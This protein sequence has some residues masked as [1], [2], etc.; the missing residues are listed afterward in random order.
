MARRRRRRPGLALGAR[1]RERE[2]LAAKSGPE[3]QA[4]FVGAAALMRRV[5]GELAGCD[6][7][8]VGLRRDCPD[9]D[10]P[11]GRPVPTGAAQGGTSA[12]R[13][14]ARTSSSPRPRG[15]SASTSSSSGR[16]R[17]RRRS[18]P[19]G[20]ARRGRACRRRGLRPAVGGQEAYLK[21]LGTGL[22]LPMS[23]VRVAEDRA[24]LL[25]GSAPQGRLER[26]DAPRA[27]SRGCA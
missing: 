1:R 14:R 13:T 12:R 5:V 8:D 4:R 16:A 6:P 25:D 18:S 20:L 21:A 11:H 26:L 10:L 24:V 9:C 17:R 22:A 15:R 3:E 2:R 27:P 19:G 23:S 7:A